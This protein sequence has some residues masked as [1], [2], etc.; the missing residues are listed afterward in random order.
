VCRRLRWTVE[1]RTRPVRFAGVHAAGALTYAVVW[2][3]GLIL[4]FSLGTSLGSGRP[5]LWL[6]S[7]AEMQWQLGAGVLLYFTIASI[8]YISET[9]QQLQEEEARAARAEALQASAELQALRGRLDPHFLFNTLHSLLELVGSGDERAQDALEVTGDLFRYVYDKRRDATGG[10]RL[11]EELTFMRSYLAVERLR[12]GD[13]LRSVTDIEPGLDDAVVPALL[14]QTLVE[15]AVRHAAAVRAAGCEVRVLVRR[16]GG[17]LRL[18]VAD[19]G[20]GADPAAIGAT[21]TSGLCL[22]ERRLRL[23][24]GAAARLTVETAP[25]AGFRVALTLPL[26]QMPAG[27]PVHLPPGRV[28]P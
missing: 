26:V 17:N 21:A 27:Q 15:N 6:L 28:E 9:T 2:A 4:L 19:D 12:L 22:A 16:E 3:A 11:G 13:R 20:P 18:D 25:G 7:A 10:V 14:L 8:L 24:Y 23:Q 1:A 5:R